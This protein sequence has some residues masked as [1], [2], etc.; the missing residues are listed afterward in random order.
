MSQQLAV[1]CRVS[2]SVYNAGIPNQ[3]IGSSPS[4]FACDPDPCAVPWE[5]NTYAPARAPDM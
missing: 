2:A 1:Q 3:G 4:C 5:G